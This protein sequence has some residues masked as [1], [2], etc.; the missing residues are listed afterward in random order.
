[1]PPL[2]G[3]ALSY[4][5]KD[6]TFKF[7]GSPG[8]IVQ[9]IASI[10]IKN[11]IYEGQEA[12]W[13]YCNE[14]WCARDPKRCMRSDSSVIIGMKSKIGTF[15]RAVKAAIASGL[16]PAPLA[17]AEQRALIC[18]K[19]P[20]NRNTGGCGACRAAANLITKGLLGRVS[21][22]YD[23]K[24]KD[25]AVCGCVLKL[26]IHYPLSEGDKHKYPSNCW[27]EKEKNKG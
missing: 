18:I 12:I 8:R 22:R 24:L 25:C 6:Q 7:V 16:K 5:I 4:T 21:T 10:Q 19:C 17:L 9:G 26:K 13:E 1:M 2:G 27:V 14:I 11:D 20:K 15:A 23:R 3:W